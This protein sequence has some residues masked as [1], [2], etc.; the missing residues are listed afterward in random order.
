MNKIIIALCG[1]LLL[2]FASCKKFLDKSPDNRAELN[3]IDK[4]AALVATAYPYYPYCAMGEMYTDN[5]AD[6]G[7]NVA[8]THVNSPYPQLYKFEDVQDDGNSTPTQFWN[9]AYQGIAAA[10]QAL[11]SIE[12][13]NLG[14]AANPYKGEALIA[15]AFNEFL[16]VTFFAKA[17]EPGGANSSPGVPYVL[18]PENNPYQKYGRGTVA[19]VYEQIEKDLTE[20]IPLLA[21]GQWDVPRYHFTAAAAH[22][23]AA[24]FYLFKGEWQKVIDH[25]N[26]VVAAGDYTGLLRDYAGAATT[27]TTDGTIYAN[28]FCNGDAK[29]NLLVHEVY[30]TY[31]RSTGFYACRYGFSQ[32]AIYAGWYQKPNATGTSFY[33][34]SRQ[35]GAGNP[36]LSKLREFFFY[37]NVTAGIG[38]PYLELPMLTTDEA[39]LNRAEAYA[40]LGNLDAALADANLCARYKIQNYNS[41][42]QNV[43]IAKARSF[44]SSSADDKTAVIN[45]ILDFKRWTFMNE[46]MRYFDILRYKMPVNHILYAN[47]NSESTVTLT[48]DDNRR[49]FQI[50]NSAVQIGG[51]EPNP[52]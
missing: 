13:Y 3:S 2:P 12:E 34:Y 16:L 29:F 7:P 36:T 40:K 8:G 47:D 46:G 48:A 37:T 22:A 30:S 33:T 39:L 45:T 14:V 1:L 4:V 11:A 50:P 17:Y 18:T 28:Y 49:M 35:Y 38:Y 24:R 21:G 15:R 5:V 41:S 32:T 52:R 43:T 42:T 44:Y 23:F 25:A 10:N 6:K 31:Q 20:G 9:G 26:Q 19:S 27:F 51:L